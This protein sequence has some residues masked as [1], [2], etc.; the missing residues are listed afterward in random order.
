MSLAFFLAL[1][2]LEGDSRI[3]ISCGQCKFRIEQTLFDS[4]SRFCLRSVLVSVGIQANTMVLNIW[5]GFK[6][7]QDRKP[8]FPFVFHLIP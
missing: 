2:F 5:V 1:A 3:F 7:S 8:V 6:K 4:K